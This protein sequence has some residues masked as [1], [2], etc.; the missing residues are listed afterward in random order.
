[1]PYRNEKLEGRMQKEKLRTGREKFLCDIL[2]YW[3]FYQAASTID[4]HRERIDVEAVIASWSNYPKCLDEFP[5]TVTKKL[6]TKEE[7]LL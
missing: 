2:R 6:D 1:M 5:S 4:F 7:L 3:G